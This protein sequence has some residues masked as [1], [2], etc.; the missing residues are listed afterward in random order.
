MTASRKD[1]GE[2]NQLNLSLCNLQGGP[3]GRRIRMGSS[4]ECPICWALRATRFPT[5]S[6]QNARRNGQTPGSVD[7]LS[8]GVKRQ[9]EASPTDAAHNIGMLR[10]LLLGPFN[11]LVTSLA[12]Q[13]WGA[14][15]DQGQPVAFGV[16]D[17]L[18]QLF[19]YEAGKSDKK[20]K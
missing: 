18:G 7:A 12:V 20:K 1:S 11:R 15:S 17:D 14:P 8:A 6:G 4:P 16:G 10:A 9:P 13:R 3:L 19:A 2:S 5:K